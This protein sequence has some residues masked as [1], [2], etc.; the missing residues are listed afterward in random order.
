[1][2]DGYNIRIFGSWS[3]SIHKLFSFNCSSLSIAILTEISCLKLSSNSVSFSFKM[4]FC[5]SIFSSSW[6]NLQQEKNF[7]ETEKCY[8]LF[9]SKF[10]R[11]I[12]KIYS[13]WASSTN[14]SCMGFCWRL[15]SLVWA[16]FSELSKNFLD[17]CTFSM[18]N[19]IS[20][21]LSIVWNAKCF[22]EIGI[23]AGDMGIRIDDNLRISAVTAICGCNFRLA[24]F[25]SSNR[26]QFVELVLSSDAGFPTKQFHWLLYGSRKIEIITHLSYLDSF[27]CYFPNRCTSYLCQ[28][29]S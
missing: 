1:M 17:S 12:L 29:K 3:L 4:S 8:L 26:Y 6:S 27:W 5:L 13:F 21:C 19:S 9:N 15:C 25:F 16:N 28:R 2:A 18:T 10:D 23:R 20:L 22:S 11:L 24:I 7:L 14:C